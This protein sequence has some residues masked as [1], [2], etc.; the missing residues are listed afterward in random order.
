MKWRKGDT[1]EQAEMLI[2]CTDVVTWSGCKEHYQYFF[3]VPSSQIP[4]DVGDLVT[5]R[6]GGLLLVAVVG[7]HDWR[8]P[9]LGRR[10]ESQ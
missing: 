7:G 10:E 9:Q 5:L 3:E 4:D 1:K 8:G 6:L 2:I